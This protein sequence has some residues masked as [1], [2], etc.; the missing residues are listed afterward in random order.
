MDDV[1]RY[2]GTA[3]NFSLS[4]LDPTL[5]HFFRLAVSKSKYL[6]RFSVDQESSSSISVYVSFTVRRFYEACQIVAKWNMGR[7]LPWANMT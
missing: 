1:Q 2:A 6:Q 7:P 4:A 3:L 5:P